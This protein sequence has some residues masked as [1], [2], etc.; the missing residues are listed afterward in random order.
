MGALLYIR[1]YA[2]HWAHRRDQVSR[3]PSPEGA[4]ILRRKADSS[5]PPNTREDPEV[6]EAHRVSTR[7]GGNQ[8]EPEALPD[9]LAVV[10]GRLALSTEQH[11]CLITLIPSPLLTEE[12]S[13]PSR[14]AH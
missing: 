12:M 2:R 7:V 4:G 9:K 3:L 8:R 13:P 1:Y 5:Q 14:Q 6:K 11:R 10:K